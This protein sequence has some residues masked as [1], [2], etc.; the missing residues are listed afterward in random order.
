MNL[1]SPG[2]TIRNLK[3]YRE[4]ISV[5]IK[6][7]FGE[8][9]ARLNLLTAYRI[10]RRVFRREPHIQLSYAVR[11]RQALEELGPTFIKLGQVLSMR[12][13]L[14]PSE[15]VIELSKLQ[16]QA[17]PLPPEVAIK[18][19]ELN[20]GQKI[21]DTFRDF[22]PIPIASASL[23]QV[24]YATLLDGTS[25]VIKI[26]RPGIK[27]V[28]DADMAILRDIALLL[29]KHVPESRQYEPVG[30]VD[31]LAKTT[32]REINFLYEGRN[33]E[34]FARKFADDP[35]I[36][37]P[38]V[39]W[40]YTTRNVLTMDRIEGIKISD[41][42]ALKEAGIDPVEVCRNGGEMVFKMIFEDGFF[43]ADPHPGNLFVTASG[44][45]APV[46]YGMVGIM[47]STQ[48]EQTAELLS[49]IVNNDPKLVV[50]S[51]KK[52]GVLPEDINETALETD[53]NEL[54]TRY[55]RIPL[56]Q[57]DMATISDEFF[58]IAH[59]HNIRVQSEFMV[60]GKALV[61]YEEVARQLDPEY[62][63]I[64]SAEPYVRRMAMRRFSAKRLKRDAQ[65]AIT[66][67]HDFITKF[68]EELGEFTS[69]LNKGKIK[70]GLEVHGL[71]KLILELD[72]SS[73]RLSFALIIAAIIVG[74]SMMMTL[75]VGLKI[76]GLP[77]LGLFGYLFAGFLGAGLAIS[78]LRSGKL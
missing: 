35:R 25:V 46:D 13:F 7:G 55:H 5:L 53:I 48:M 23:S 62:D 36:Y 18:A 22:N 12:P 44:R 66:E 49:A 60:F 20:L 70:V 29:E 34:A 51:F 27:R 39:F 74:S 4:I 56:A 41:I 59:R 57:I 42:A 17:A 69:K 61:T 63:F 9:V 64:K 47:S 76:Y 33:I 38:R 30:L 40:S 54:I 58:E 37:I 65:I 28:I 75:N 71:D 77:V 21:E 68:P 43:H 32:R 15:L 72:K 8:V 2:K 3:R 11:I 45:I 6:Y 10:G 24:H 26:Q 31:E 16:D 78:I 1:T 52:A 50:Y 19:I 67:L 73:N 14:I